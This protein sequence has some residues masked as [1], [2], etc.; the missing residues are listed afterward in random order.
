MAAKDLLSKDEISAL[1]HS[2]ED[3]AMDARSDSLTQAD[4]AYPYDVRRQEIKMPP[5]PALDGVYENLI[6][7]LPGPLSDL[8]GCSIEVAAASRRTLRFA[9]YVSTL[10]T[11]ASFNLVR[12][13]QLNLSCLVVLDAS[14]VS[15]IVNQLFGGDARF[16]IELNRQELTPTEQRLVE[17]LVR[18]FLKNFS[19]VWT[20]CVA[21]DFEFVKAEAHPQSIAANGPDSQALVT[22]L[23]VRLQNHTGQIHVVLPRDVLAV[24]GERLD[25]PASSSVRQKN[26]VDWDASL[27]NTLNDVPLE[28]RCTLVETQIS[29]RQVMCLKTGDVIPVDIPEEAMLYIKG[30]PAFNAKFGVLRGSYAVKILKPRNGD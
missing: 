7:Q 27:Q 17:R 29:L 15:G 6:R 8:L 10:S 25:S 12:I 3:G 16:Q 11:P 21:L 20:P 26:D 23:D 14:L 28:L 4:I 5:L 22:A 24:L 9:E 2:V 1:L 18:L 30:V 19:D 13:K